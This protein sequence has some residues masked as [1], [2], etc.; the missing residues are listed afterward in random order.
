M[1]T[2]IAVLPIVIWAYLL[3]G[4][5]WFWWIEPFKLAA[6][7]EVSVGESRSSSRRATKPLLSRRSS[8]VGKP[9]IMTALC[10]SSSWTT[11]ARM[12]P[13]T[14]AGAPSE[15]RQ[16]SNFSALRRSR[17]SGPGNSGRC[18]AASTPR[19]EFA[20]DYFLFTDADI[21]HAPDTLRSLIAQA[22]RGATTSC[23]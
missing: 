11:I 23:P 9:T 5:H 22:E 7:A 14:I 8:P 2:V 6:A 13:P 1:L 16:R 4:R 19:G 21:V 18:P 17:R 15:A 12:A 20:P 3:L 10:A